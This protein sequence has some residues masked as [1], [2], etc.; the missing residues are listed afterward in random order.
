MAASDLSRSNTSP[1]R[2]KKWAVRGFATFVVLGVLAY[3]GV[4]AFFYGS[5]ESLIF[6]PVPLPAAYVSTLSDTTEVAIPV[7]GATLSALHFKRPDAKGVVFFL[8]GNSGNVSSWLKTT[9]FYAK[10]N[11]DVFMIDYRG[12][13]KST[14]HIESEAQLHQDVMTAWKFIAPQYEGRKR[15]IFGR[16]LGATLAAKLASEVTPDWT[17]LVSPFYNLNA[18]REDYYAYLPAALMRYTFTTNAWL[19]KIKTP[20]TIVH[21]DVDPLI[22][23]SHAERL[24]AIAPNTELVKIE[25]GTHSNLHH[26]QSYLDA[27]SAK[28]QKL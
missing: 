8:H 24:H 12:Y 21:G 20:V 28:M 19:P 15:A 9:D 22:H 5:Q 2:L 14:G 25:G 26:L 7:D 6:K 11:F 3:G 16:S 17:A 13:G 18:M 23:F 27:L 1:R 10:N 4:A